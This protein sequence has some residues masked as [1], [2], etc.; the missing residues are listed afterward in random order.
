MWRAIARDDVLG[1]RLGVFEHLQQVR[2]QGWLICLAQPVCTR[3]DFD[4]D[5]VVSLA[6][7]APFVVVLLDPCSSLQHARCAAN[8]NEDLSIDGADIELF[9]GMLLVP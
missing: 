5:G 3:G 9:V 2:A 1:A 7:V 4:D 6:D 8:V